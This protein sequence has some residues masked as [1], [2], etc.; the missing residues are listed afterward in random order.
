MI[1][2]FTKFDQFEREVKFK[3]EDQRRDLA[4]LSDE[5]ESIFAHHYLASL[6][7][8]PPFV[9]LK[10]EGIVSQPTSSML[11]S[12]LQKCTGLANSVLTLSK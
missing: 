2:V 6:R 1:A 5:V 10:G 11:I 8:P 4:L 3:L 7:G 9:C 12:V